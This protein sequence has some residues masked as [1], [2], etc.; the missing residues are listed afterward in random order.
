[1]YHLAD[2]FDLMD[3][4][5]NQEA[6]LL[7]SR[8]LAACEHGSQAYLCWMIAMGYAY[9]N[10]HAYEKALEVYEQYMETAQK[11]R[12]FEDL[13]VGLH[14]KGM[15]LR[16]MKRYGDALACFD[17]ER[18]IIARYFPGDDLKL[19]V[20]EYEQGYCRF[21]SGDSKAGLA[22]MQR[23]LEHA[24]K[25]GDLTARA[26]ACRGLGEIFKAA[27]SMDQAGD[28]FDRARTL[29]MEAGDAVGAEEVDRIRS[30]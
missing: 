16:L 8:N 1:M 24:L 14:Q 22:H 5:E 30:E 23:S 13:H 27:Q 21:L 3:R 6:L 17:G 2:A 28:C 20:N 15:T 7:I 18:E 4:G 26:C 12:A 9:C 11:K 25:T 10:L 29:F 19:S